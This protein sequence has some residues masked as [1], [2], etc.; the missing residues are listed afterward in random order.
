MLEVFRRARPVLVY[1]ISALFFALL[2]V[3]GCGGVVNRARPAST[4]AVRVV[5]DWPVG[6]SRLLP[7]AS[8]A[9]KAVVE[10]GGQTYYSQPVVISR[11]STTASITGVPA[12]AATLRA[13][14]Y[15]NVDGSGTAQASGAQGMTIVA[16]QQAQVVLTLA[17]TITQV[18]VTPSPA[19]LVVGNE[20]LLEA[21]AQD[22]SA[23]RVPLVALNAFTWAVLSGTGVI[24]VN[25]S[26]GLVRALAAGQATITATEKESGV[27]GTASISVSAPASG[28]QVT[29][30]RSGSAPTIDGTVTDAEWSGATPLSMSFRNG[31]GN[32]SREYTGYFTHDGQWLYAGLRTPVASGWDAYC[33]IALDGDND[34]QF[35]GQSSY[36]HKDLLIGQPGPGAWGG[37]NYYNWDHSGV[38]VS[39]PSGTARA[40]KSVSGKL[41]FEFKIQLG[42]LSTAAGRTMGMLV[43]VGEDGTA[44]NTDF[45]PAGSGWSDVTKWAQAVLA[46]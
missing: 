37:Y 8:A 34:Q 16:A 15:P 4:G 13:W 21:R 1:R 18:V 35:V 25:A 10:A 6:E 28:N 20:L 38:H 33:V 2:G 40:S 45:F 24:E 39:E 11:P 12:G 36:P 9:V 41:H 3:A 22:A 5:V 44:A 30:V 26:T 42:D 32:R 31:A 46:P 29:V 14:A 19:V 17:S 27:A 43:S 7:A 23:Q